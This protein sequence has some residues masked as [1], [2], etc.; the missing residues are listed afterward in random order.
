M[1]ANEELD[2]LVEQTTDQTEQLIQEEEFFADLEDLTDEEEEVK[3][4][5][6]VAH[7]EPESAVQDL[8]YDTECMICCS[9][10]VE[11]C[12]LPCK[13]SFCV[14]CLNEWFKKRRECAYCTAVTPADFQL[15]VNRSLQADIKR[16]VPQEYR[17]HLT[18]LRME[19]KMTADTNDLVEL[20]IIFGNRHEILNARGRNGQ[21]NRH[22][23]TMFIDFKNLPV[24]RFIDKVRFG[25]NK[26]FGQEYRDVYLNKGK[27]ELSFTGYS[28][29]NIPIT[30]F[31]KPELFQEEDIEDSQIDLEHLLC[32]K[33]QGKWQ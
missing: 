8:I 4:A 21:R 18:K 25:L 26:S 2:Q 9:T 19:N 16:A 17:Q 20:P 7:K 28:P 3:Y 1:T 5:V 14:Q 31:F 15:S 12:T 27:L 29:L 24:A 11:P 30:I 6:K 13:H 10:M 33:G 23:W 22:R 32:F